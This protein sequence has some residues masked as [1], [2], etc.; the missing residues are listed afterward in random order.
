MGEP[1]F[2]IKGFPSFFCEFL[3]GCLRV[4]QLA[5]TL[6]LI[7]RTRVQIQQES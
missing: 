2:G 4:H 1:P 3:M 5:D 7:D 6:H